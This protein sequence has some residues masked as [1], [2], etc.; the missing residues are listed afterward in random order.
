MAKN[1]VADRATVLTLAALLLMLLLSGVVL[2][3]HL[4]YAAVAEGYGSALLAGPTPLDPPSGAPGG[5]R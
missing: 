3:V 5:H 1:P 4:A 2:S